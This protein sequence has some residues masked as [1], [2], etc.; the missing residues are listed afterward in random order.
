MRIKNFCV[1]SSHRNS[2]DF[3]KKNADNSVHILSQLEREFIIF[4]HK[5]FVFR[6][7]YIEFL[8]QLDNRIN[9]RVGSKMDY[10]VKGW[11]SEISDLWQGQCFSLKVKEILHEEQSDFQSIKILQT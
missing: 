3:N 7:S 1:L 2:L 11:F 5:F 4:V 8:E 10:L 6:V 9:C